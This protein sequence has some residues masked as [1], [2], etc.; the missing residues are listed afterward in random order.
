M[1]VKLVVFDLDGV[2]IDSKQIHYEALNRALGK[3]YAIDIEE[4]L[5]TYDGL[6]TRAKLNMLTESK[7]L[8]TDKHADIAICNLSVCITEYLFIALL[9]NDSNASLASF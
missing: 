2:L 1:T 9:L 4:H 8:P 3:E 7:G 6:P 5:S